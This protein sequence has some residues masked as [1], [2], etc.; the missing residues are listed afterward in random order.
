MVREGVRKRYRIFG[1]GIRRNFNKDEV[2]ILFVKSSQIFPK[3]QKKKNPPQ[4]EGQKATHPKAPERHTEHSSSSVLELQKLHIKGH[5]EA[6]SITKEDEM[7][8]I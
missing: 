4:S 8:E 5:E 7:D 2:V 1:E 3:P 6:M